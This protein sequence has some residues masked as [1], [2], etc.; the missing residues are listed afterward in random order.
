MKTIKE[1]LMRR[2]RLTE[3]EANRRIENA[4]EDL[5]NRMKHNED[6][7]DLCQEWFRLE[8]DYVYELCSKLQ[9]A[10][11]AKLQEAT[12]EESK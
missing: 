1:L 12:S 2:D 5:A 9:E 3:E 10:T 11:T 7:S 8:Q 4:T 6:A